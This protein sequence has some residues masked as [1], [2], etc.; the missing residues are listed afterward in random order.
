MSEIRGA[1][2]ATWSSQ[3]S[4]IIIERAD[5]YGGKKQL[6]GTCS[7]IENGLSDLCRL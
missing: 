6:P 2:D 7:V 3:S 5:V 1:R 4:A